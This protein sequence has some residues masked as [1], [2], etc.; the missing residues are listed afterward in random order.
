MEL[1]WPGEDPAKLSNR[2]SVALATLR[3]VLGPGGARAGRVRRRGGRPLGGRRR[4]RALPARARR[5]RRSTGATSSRR[6]CTRTGRPTCA[7]RRARR[8]PAPSARSRRRRTGDEAVRLHLRLLELDRWDAEAH[9]ALIAQL[10]DERPARRGAAAQARLR[11]RHGRDRGPTLRPLERLW[12]TVRRCSRALLTHPS[13]LGL[14]AAPCRP[15][16]ARSTGAAAATGSSAPPPRVPLDY[17]KPAGKQISLAVI[18][19]PASD[20]GAGS[21]RCSST[22]AARATRPS[23]SCAATPRRSTRPRC[24]P[25]ST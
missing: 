24:S 5:A 23:T 12:S 7:R 18:R 25:A 10:E 22:T 4:R 20:P 13:L 8:T 1:L 14:V 21:A 15:R 2:L 11:G 19:R 9:L 16:R 17:D 6:T 3:S